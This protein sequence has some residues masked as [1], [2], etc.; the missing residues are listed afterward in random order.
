MGIGTVPKYET[1]QHGVRSASHMP[2]IRVIQAPSPLRFVMSSR[3]CHCSP[4]G[5]L[6]WHCL[7]FLP[8]PWIR[9]KREQR[10]R[11]PRA[12]IHTLTRRRTCATGNRS[13]TTTTQN[14]SKLADVSRSVGNRRR[15]GDCLLRHVAFA[16]TLRSIKE[17]NTHPHTKEYRRIARSITRDAARGAS[18]RLHPAYNARSP[19]EQARGKRTKKKEHKERAGTR[20]RTH[21][22]ETNDA[23]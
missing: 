15:V 16:R 20:T 11:S 18:P 19:C 12:H 13:T 2:A 8:F 23:S 17:A 21:K 5:G 7:C 4:C 14:R 10:I 3:K 9:G 22:S 1:P 6:A